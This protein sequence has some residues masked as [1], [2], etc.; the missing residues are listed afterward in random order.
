MRV[1]IITISKTKSEYSEAEAEFLK[2]LTKYALV[3]ILNLKEE[4][5]TKNRSIDEI[6]E[7][8]GERILKNLD[9]DYYNIALH[10]MGKEIT[11]VELSNLIKEIRD[12]KSGK[13]CFIIGGPLGLSKEVLTIVDLALSMSKMTFT[14]QLIRLLLLEQIYRGFEII[15]NTGYHK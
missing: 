7:K 1:K 15:N 10:V 13:I 9:K 4:L 14:H 6:M 8:E 3:E 2:R 5:I 11:S 12:F